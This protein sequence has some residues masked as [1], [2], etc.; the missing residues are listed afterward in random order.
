MRDGQQGA[1]LEVYLISRMIHYYYYCNSQL[2]EKNMNTD[3][4]SKMLAHGSSPTQITCPN[5]G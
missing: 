1:G 3:S 2:S 4:L 5:E